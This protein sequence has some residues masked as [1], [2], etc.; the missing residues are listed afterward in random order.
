MDGSAD[1]DVFAALRRGTGK[2]LEADGC[3]A[4]LI[5]GPVV[6]T[7][8]CGWTVSGALRTFRFLG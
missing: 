5:G 4:V 8:T 1:D 7:S 6:K 3:A 2:E